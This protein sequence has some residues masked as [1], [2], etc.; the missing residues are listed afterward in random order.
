MIWGVSQVQP[1]G[2]MMGS[3]LRSMRLTPQK[4]QHAQHAQ[5]CMPRRLSSLQPPA[6][7]TQ[8]L[9]STSALQGFNPTT[10]T[11]QHSLQSP[12]DSDSYSASQDGPASSTESPTSEGG[13]RN[14]PTLT[15]ISEL[16]IQDFALVHDQRVQFTPG[17]NVITG[18]S[19][20]GK[21]VLVEAIA[22]ILGSPAREGYVRPPASTAVLEGTFQ[23][24][25]SARVRSSNTQATP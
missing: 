24:S 15:H 7:Q 16:R 5:R 20:S 1:S 25:N 2:E 12:A 8:G 3:L 18:E 6:A 19:G 22:A 4:V 9:A 21:S 11:S 10:A 13:S 17:L 14:T 23:L